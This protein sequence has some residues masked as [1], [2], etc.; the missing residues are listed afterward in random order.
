MTPS[1]TLEPAFGDPARRGR[2]GN[3]GDVVSP[4]PVTITAHVPEGRRRCRRAPRHSDRHDRHAGDVFPR[5]PGAGHLPSRRD[6]HR[7]GRGFGPHRRH[8][9]HPG[10]QHGLHQ[11]GRAERRGARADGQQ[12]HLQE[13]LLPWWHDRP[14]EHELAVRDV[15]AP[16]RRIHLHRLHVPAATPELPLGRVA[17]LRIHAAAV[18][19]QSG[20]RPGPGVQPQQRT[21]WGG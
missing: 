13:L 10:Q 7:R 4:E 17:G 15:P 6:D 11:P 1:P 3:G 12:R 8:E 5:H 16:R 21:R 19:H 18:R 9:P 20:R 14:A 2:R